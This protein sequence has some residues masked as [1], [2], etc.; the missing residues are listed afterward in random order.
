MFLNNSIVELLI[1]LFLVCVTPRAGSVVDVKKVEIEGRY[2][3]YGIL[4]LLV[5]DRF[6]YVCSKS[7]N[8]V[9]ASVVCRQ[10]SYPEGGFA[11]VYPIEHL[12]KG[13]NMTIL[14]LKFDCLGNESNLSQC[15]IT[16]LDTCEEEKVITI[17][18]EMAVTVQKVF[19]GPSNRLL[20]LIDGKNSSMCFNEDLHE[21]LSDIAC[22]QLGYTNGGRF[23]R[24][25]ADPKEELVTYNFECQPRTTRLEDC[26]VRR[27]MACQPRYRVT[28]LCQSPVNITDVQLTATKGIQYGVV[29]VQVNQ[30][31]YWA[32]VCDMND[33]SNFTTVICRQLGFSEGTSSY[34]DMDYCSNQRVKLSPIMFGCQGTESRLDQ[35]LSYLEGDSCPNVQD[36]LKNKVPHLTVTCRKHV[37]IHAVNLT[38]TSVSNYGVLEI[39]LEAN[40]PFMAV[41]DDSFNSI[42]AVVACKQ[43][44][45]KYGQYQPASALG[46]TQQD[47]VGIKI[48]CSSEN[49]THLNECMV[50]KL[51]G[52][53]SRE[54]V[55]LFCSN[56]V[57]EEKSLQVRIDGTDRYFGGISVKK[58][59][60]WGPVCN[61]GWTNTEA[62]SACRALD[63]KGG[64]SYYASVGFNESNLPI[65]VGRFNCSGSDSF[66][67]CQN[68][69]FG[70]DLGCQYPITKYSRRKVAG[71]LCFENEA[72]N[73]EFRLSDRWYGAVEIK[74]ENKWGRVCNK[75]FD[76]VDAG[77]MCRQLGYVDGRVSNRKAKSNAGTVRMD[78][79]N[80]T[81]DEASILECQHEG[82]W[83]RNERGSDCSD[84]VVQCNT[85]ICNSKDIRNS[86]VNLQYLQNCT[87]IEGNLTI[88]LIDSN[89]MDDYNKYS[90][91]NLVE[92][93]EFLLLFRAKGLKTLRGLFPNLAVIR[94]DQLLYGYAIVAFEMPDLEELG[95]PSLVSV[96]RGAVR[97][98]KNPNLC[99]IET[100]DW[101]RIV[102]Q[103]TDNLF[104]QNKMLSECVD[105]CHESCPLVPVNGKNRQLCWGIAPSACQKTCS[106]CPSGFCNGEQ[107]CNNYCLGGCTGPEPTQCTTCRDVMERNSEGFPQC[108]QKCSAGTYIYRKHRCLLDHE[109]LNFKDYSTTQC[110]LEENGPMRNCLKLVPFPDRTTPGECAA[111]CPPDF[112]VDPLNP[113]KCQQC[114]GRCPKVCENGRYIDTIT[115]AQQ[116]RECNIIQGPLFINFLS[117][118][119]IGEELERSLAHIQEVTDFISITHSEAPL[120]LHFFKS[121]SKISGKKLYR[122]K[123]ILYIYDN[124][125]LQELFLEDVAA[126]LT[127]GNGTIHFQNNHK[128]CYNKIAQFA[129]AVGQED[130]LEPGTRETNGDDVPCDIKKLDLTMA[131]A[132]P[133]MAFLHYTRLNT[134]DDRHLI[135]YSVNWKI[136]ESQ[137]ISIY[138]NR[139]ACS[140]DVWQTKE[141]CT[142]N[143]PCRELLLYIT[144]LQ[145]WTQYAAYIEAIT[146]TKAVQGA[147]SDILYFRTSAS[148]P[149]SPTNLQIQATRPGELDITWDP[150]SQARGNITHYQ[151]YW[152]MRTLNETT[153]ELRDYCTQPLTPYNVKLEEDDEIEEVKATGAGG[154]NNTNNTDTCPCQCPKTEE[155]KEVEKRERE[156]DILFQDYLQNK[157]YIKRLDDASTTM[158]ARRRRERAPTKRSRRSETEDTHSTNKYTYQDSTEPSVLNNSDETDKNGSAVVV[159]EA[160]ATSPEPPTAYMAVVYQ[161]RR[162]VITGLGHFLDYKIEVIACQA[163][164][165]EAQSTRDKPEMK[166]KCSQEAIGVGR[167]MKD[168]ESDSL[169]SSLVNTTMVANNSNA[170]HIKWQ[171]PVNPNGLIVTYEI[172][173]KKSNIQ[174]VKPNTICI[175]Y[176]VYR[177]QYQRGYTLDK[178]DSGNYTFRIRA[179]SLAGNGSWTEYMFFTISAKEDPPTTTATLVGILVTV[180]VVIIIITIV[181]VWLVARHKF[182]KNMNDPMKISA[183][184]D[185]YPDYTVYKP[186]EWEVDRDKVKLLKELGAGSFGMVYEGMYRIEDDRE[187]VRVAVKT[188]NAN[189]TDHDRYNFL[190]EASIMKAFRCHHVVRLIGVVSINQPALV[191]MELMPHGDLKKFLRLHRPDEPENEG[192]RPPMLKQILQMAGEIADG[193]AYLADKKYVHRDLAARNCMVGENLT[194]KIADFGMTRDIY[195]RDYYRKGTR[196]LLPV[197]WMAP[198][199]LKD[200]VFTSMTDVWS[201]GVVLWEMATLAEQPYQGLANEEVLQYVGIGKIMEMPEGCPQLLYDLMVKCWRFRPKQRPT[202][203]EIIEILLPHLNRDFRDVSYFFSEEKAQYDESKHVTT[204]NVV[205]N[206]CTADQNSEIGDDEEEE[207]LN[208]CPSND[209]VDEAQLPM[210]PMVGASNGHSVE[211]QDIFSDTGGTYPHYSSSHNK[212]HVGSAEMCDCTAPFP[213]VDE[214]A[215]APPHMELYN[216]RS[217]CSSPNSAIGGSSDGSKDSSKSSSSSYAHMNGLSLANG[218][219]PV[220]LRTTPC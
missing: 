139:D 202:F 8:N 15:Y 169:N 14:P 74:Y 44:G 125:N 3:S 129:R 36:D 92:I 140:N 38:R 143:N 20:V 218:H 17:N 122:D 83:N 179:T 157:I 102:K 5:R 90:F 71:V 105:K 220:N 214:G 168:E 153:Y 84:A 147:I 187:E 61:K 175:T 127:L 115:A 57:I 156:M 97:L 99:Y 78:N 75:N 29:Q 47:I 2:Q 184:P 197:R 107:C 138:K 73:I 182:R 165:R 11:S 206:K 51:W 116:L 89:S 93:T 72:N 79:I 12:Q 209:Y 40:G 96:P 121:L 193:M 210:L 130:N 112:V 207:E 13:N 111:D 117:G 196:G 94:G 106:V 7:F 212:Q 95:L 172:E 155:E 162:F 200:G 108:K 58:Y 82:Y 69:G 45:Y 34:D 217:V 159:I 194:I 23:A 85:T 174:H 208:G 152:T 141:I 28:L 55:S 101:T 113:Q 87:V 191:L 114:T 22:K 70:A 56:D 160:A 132:T 211:L 203:K 146:V 49:L 33:V 100:I 181:V 149:S 134:T 161:E 54:Y 19:M 120:S 133:H 198:E 188:T 173:Y 190:Q 216:R 183:N 177:D 41:C 131:F 142:E 68:R 30:G 37:S 137:N 39:Q 91:P 145:P 77:V 63:F 52:C 158:A 9:D 21:G 86:V 119:N 204:H 178:L 213:D 128:L 31:Q 43:L 103:H 189:S 192:R 148:V 104:K 164:E 46:T 59:G 124:S 215:A 27:N 53:I 185:Y 98:T 76:D 154:D 32:H 50:K 109:C 110:Q 18:C 1:L 67:N 150:P 88:L 195:E 170:V 219:V 123:Y 199:S 25:T 26:T 144:N 118:S 205:T 4:K 80:C 151:V 126:N 64:V 24:M 65:A 180:V 48:E 10:N 66:A 62:R 171:D 60:F 42:A 136:A 81:G 166:M 16:Q 176:K 35:C 135:G 167:T 186:D 201:Y 163:R 6:V